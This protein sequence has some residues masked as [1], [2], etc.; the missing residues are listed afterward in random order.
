[1]HIIYV[2]PYTICKKEF[3]TPP[4]IYDTFDFILHFLSFYVCTYF[5][6]LY[7]DPKSMFKEVLIKQYYG[8]NLPIINY[9]YYS[10]LTSV[11]D[12]AFKGSAKS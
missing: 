1:M 2:P 6:I 11:I 8:N 3:T 4:V 5:L 10:F 9:T 7:V 12:I